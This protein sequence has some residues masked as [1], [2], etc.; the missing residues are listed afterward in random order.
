MRSCGPFLLELLKFY[1]EKRVNFV[2]MCFQGLVDVFLMI[3]IGTGLC[4]GCQCIKVL[5]LKEELLELKK[6][7]LLF[8]LLL[9]ASQNNIILK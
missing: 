6:L 9:E 7:L 4:A 3:R 5:R 1:K 8:V 2:C